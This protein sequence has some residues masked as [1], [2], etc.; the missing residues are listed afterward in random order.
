MTVIQRAPLASATRA[1]T[2]TAVL[3]PTNTGKTHLAIERLLG[4]ASGAIGL[5][6]RLLARE[7]YGR[8]SARAGVSQV[9]LV[10]GEEKIVPPGARYWVSTVEAMPRDLDVAFVAIDEVQLAGDLERGHV[11]T[12]RLL[13]VRGTHET[14]LLG[15]ATARPL[16]E[17][18][19]PGVNVVSRPRLSQLVYAGEKKLTRLPQRSAIV[20][21]SAE[22]VYA[23][24]ELIRRQRGGAAVVMG[25]LSPRTRNAQVALFQNGDVDFLVATDAVGMGLNLDVDHVAFA[26]ARK[27]D[28]YQ[29]RNLTPS[30]LGQIAGRAGRFL[31]DGTFGVTGRVAP[32]DEDLVQAI[33]S[34]DFEPVKTFQW[35]NADLDF[36]SV[37]ALR[38]SLDRQPNT[39]GLARALPSDDQRALDHALRDEAVADRAAGRDRVGLLWD[40]CQVPDFRK[41]SP[42][43][44][45]D[46]VISLYR[47]LTDR[48]RIPDDWFA[49]QVGLADRVDGDIDSLSQRLADI[50]TWTFVANRSAWLDDP[51]H[52]QDRTRA[53]E[54]RLSDALHDRL[55]QRFVDRRTS[56]LMKRLRENAMLEAEITGTGAVL[57]EGQHV[58]ELHGFRFLPDPSTVAESPDGKA[59]RAAAAKALS[60]EFERRA[61][62]ISK[63]PNDDVVLSSD[64]SLR[65]LGQP[66]AKLLPGED[67][68]APRVQLL[69]DEQLTG[70]ARDKV[71]ARLDLWVGAHVGTLLKPLVDL[72]TAADLE[73]LARGVAFRMV[74]ALG[75][76]E[77]A[78]VADDVKALDQTQRA[79]MRKHGV[80]FGAYHI[81]VPALLKP[82]PAA[83]VAQLWAL[84]HGTLDMPGLAELP[85][86]S[87]SGR[88]SI[89]VDPTFE[90]TL[91]R[92]VGFRVAGERA[93]RIDI[94]ERLAD[95]IRPL[96]AWKPT[97]D[98]AT[99]PDGAIA[100]GG[101]FTVT[102]AMT[103]LLGCSGEDFASILRGLGY[104]MEKRKVEVPVRPAAAAA[105]APEATASPVVVAGSAAAVA[106]PDGENAESAGMDEPEGAPAEAVA[107][108]TAEAPA[109]AAAAETVD[110]VGSAEV[111][112]GAAPAEETAAPTEAPA[113]AAEA[114]VAPAESAPAE[115]AA[116]APVLEEREI[117]IWRP[118]RFDRGRRPEQGRHGHGHGGPRRDD[119][120][121]RQDG[122]R[123]G[124]GRGEGRGERRPDRNDQPRGDRRPE[125]GAP[126]PERHD[127][128]SGPRR[129]DRPAAAEA[130]RRDD[131]RP[132]QE[133][134]PKRE[135]PVDPSSP[136]AALA[137]LKADLEQRQKKK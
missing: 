4:H 132:P 36:A 90:K 103:S 38:R 66:V 134:A 94:L 9:A 100:Q 56:V 128:P 135:K 136:F 26:Q 30:E 22:E 41:I 104:R 95:I 8:I 98:G 88:T 37:A 124:E 15:S 69:A 83:L 96:I 97:G 5:P 60:S 59:V 74:E 107:A 19:M 115:A 87:A 129:D 13:N 24:A 101:A 118:G 14:L 75:T 106:I 51:L 93:V 89:K 62:R 72:R 68:L 79:V 125:G 29:F 85:Q 25:A 54:D 70:P 27:F 61:D 6:L 33:E 39:D 45:G 10:T 109:E 47:F 20:A 2:V 130:P 48:G 121:P 46:L 12:D 122:G 17:K 50:R 131:R 80:R 65:W 77:R 52:W 105:A 81:Y 49:R 3:G 23:V 7:V 126:R 73:G 28:G 137:A 114:E 84:K 110:A 44:H 76:L 127:R 133:R 113:E 63:A 35:R 64:G 116:E 34:H 112:V 111:E 40:T 99:P 91:Y 120:A 43:H 1:R 78:E 42:A 86:L 53:I 31:N 123:G 108:E 55:T 117:E 71:Q 16:I 58:G 18:L 57:V 32:F 92:L 82:A 67:A 11:F 21:F 102:V 119:R